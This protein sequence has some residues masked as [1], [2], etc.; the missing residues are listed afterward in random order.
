[1]FLVVSLLCQWCMASNPIPDVMEVPN[2]PGGAQVS[3]KRLSVDSGGKTPTVK[4]FDLD[5]IRGLIDRGEP[6]VYTSENSSNFDYI[7]MPIGGIGSGQLYLGGDGRLWH[8]DI[9]NTRMRPRFTVEQGAAYKNPPKQN[10]PD[11]IKQYVLDQGFALRIWAGG[12]SQTRTLDRRGFSDIEF[13]GQY[14]IGQVT[15]QDASVPVT[16]ELEAFSPFIPLKVEDSSYPATVLNYTISNKS[17]KPVEGALAGWLENKVCVFN[18]K[19]GA[20]IH[21]NRIVRSDDMV[22]L[23]QDAEESKASDKEPAEIVFEDFESGTFDNWTVEGVAFTEKPKKVKKER[24]KIVGQYVADSRACDSAKKPGKLLSKSFVVEHPYISFMIAGGNYPR[25]ARINLIVDGKT[26]RSSTGRHKGDVDWDSWEVKKLKGKDARIEIAYDRAPD[27]YRYILVDQI[28]FRSK[29]RKPAVKLAEQVDFG[30]MALAI[31]SGDKEVIAAAQVLA[32]DVPDSVFVASGESTESEFGEKF[33]GAVG[34]K[35]TLAPGEKTTVSFVLAWYFPNPLPLGLKTPTRRWYAAKFESVEQVVED[36]QRNIERLT[37]ETRLWRDTWY[38]STL[39]YWFL[40][41]TF[42]N[43]ST[44]ATSTCY[45]F[46]DDRFYGFEGVYSC[47]GTCTHVWGY[48]QALGRLFPELEKRLR[49]KADFNPKI[50]FK[51]NTGGCRMRGEYS[52]GV[53]VDGQSGIILRTYREH[54]MSAD[55]A[56]LKRNYESVKKAMGY[57]VNTY[58]ADADG[59]MEGPQHNTLDAAWYG[60]ITWLSLY[61]QAALRATAEMADEMKDTEYASHLRA[62]AD[63]G[64][65]YIE[66]ELFNGEYFIHQADPKHPDSPGSYDGCEYDQLLG[67]SWAYQVG[68]GRILDYQKT[69]TA[70]NSLWKY[71]FTTDVGPYREVFKT[72]RWFAMPSEGGII[73]CTFPYGGSDV[74]KKG[75]QFYA[76]YLNE[77]QPGYEYAVGSLM[78]WHGLVDKGLMQ[79]RSMHERYLG[80]KRNPWNEVECGSHYSRSMASHGAFIAASG[81]E[82]HGP[83]GYLAFAPRVTP[84]NFRASF[85]VAQGWG[86]YSQQS[87]PTNFKAQIVQKWGKLRI[88]T[89]AFAVAKKP[90]KISV[91]VNGRSVA[92][93][94]EFDKGRAEITLATD[95]VIT[96]NEKIEVIIRFQHDSGRAAAAKEPIT[97]GHDK[98]LVAWVTPANLKQRGGGVLTISDRTGDFDSVVF[99]ERN[100][101][102]WMAG[103]GDQLRTQKNQSGNAP[104]TASAD[105]LV[106]IAVVYRRTRVEIWRNAKLYASYDIDKRP[107]IFGS[108]RLVLMG[109]RDY[110]PKGNRYFAGSIEDARIYNHALDA[111]QIAA[112]KP[113]QLSNPEPLAWWSFE[114]GKA[115]DLMK[116]FTAVRLAGGARIAGGRLH[117][118]GRKS[119]LA[120][121]VHLARE[122]RVGSNNWPRYHVCIPPDELNTGPYDTNGCIYWKG[123]YHL[124]YIFQDPT[125]PYRGHSYGH[126]SSTDLINWTYHP[127][128]LGAEPGDLGKGIFSGNAFVNKQGVPMMSWNDIKVG[129]S[130]ATAQDDDLIKWE[131]HPKNPV[132]QR[133]KKGIPNYVYIGDPHTWLEGDTYYSAISGTR[134][135]NNEHVLFLYRSKDLVNWEPRH[136]FYEGDPTLAVPGEDIACPDFFKLGNKHVL[137]GIS[138]TVGARCYIG[139]FDK[140][141]EKFFPER[142][143]RMNWPG[144][145]FFAPDSLEDDQGRRIF[146]T[147]VTDARQITP[148]RTTLPGFHSLPRV[149]SLDK[150][151]TLLIKPVK[152]LETL[153]RNHRTLS[154]IKLAADS[155][156][157][158]PSVSGDCLELTV[159]IDPGSARQ[160]GLAIRCSPDDAERTTIYYDADSKSLKMDMSWSTLRDDVAYTRYTLGPGKSTPNVVNAPF[161][162]KKGETL[163]LHVFLDKPMLE[164]F[165]NDR[166]AIGQQVFP[167]RKDSLLIKAFAKGGIATVRKIDAWD[168]AAAKFVDERAM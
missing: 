83:K 37:S 96:A 69:T 32:A 105:T 85:T 111:S 99:A 30:S 9:F 82:Y 34:R 140:E 61:Y 80:A 161:E 43:V 97:I 147:W 68:L 55:D 75:D 150:D 106:Q 153:R 134:L 73:G 54:Q 91:T 28:E 45:L 11:D 81:Y 90:L 16:V 108:E 158:L 114:N 57:L 41:R 51:E 110:G 131:K 143:I 59:I 14:P 136:P 23:V 39:P 113:N 118:D 132:I 36:V 1:M 120:A 163:K 5:D 63:R 139:R 94:H 101:R 121:G 64:R 76:G 49:E 109:V 77:C 138:H 26:V 42:L 2:G 156:T 79:V 12:K 122:Y 40:D 128:A 152:E 17:D 67:Q 102:R 162:L 50:G 142:H 86:T 146:W 115:D 84:G 24:P 130:V 103:S 141:K 53:A 65:K 89:L 167:K 78:I 112:L 18:G 48:N 70:L 145:N 44:L 100:E 27:K 3:L 164:V 47:P 160:V 117:L 46:E 6:I 126:V 60:K 157:T 22:M 33:I 148:K 25:H 129:M 29:P 19:V 58:D 21:R 4:K 62:T 127:T 7:G 155:E 159:E 66:K 92:V 10:D 137:L 20:G 74:L 104:E 166:Q 72:G 88:K 123:R 165:A 87:G 168:M 116:T 149:M 8:W 154:E 35:F 13:K 119:Y 133:Q 71:N 125:R 135:A 144:A 98:T 95:A 93:T 107:P 151:G 38:D 15:Y 124:M 52:D 31:L 56:F